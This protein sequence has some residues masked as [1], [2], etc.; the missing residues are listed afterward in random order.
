MLR[1][2]F[3]RLYR[4]K[5]D[6]TMKE[7]QELIKANNNIVLLDVRS[8]QEYNEGHLNGAINI[9]LHELGFKAERILKDKNSI[10]I[11]YCSAGIRSKKAVVLL[12]KLG[13][14]N[15]YNILDV[16]L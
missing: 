12:K 4:S 6:I 3:K 16:K 10:I 7:F 15:L 14:R 8:I 9:P 2:V 11:A 1:N 13:Y 5:E